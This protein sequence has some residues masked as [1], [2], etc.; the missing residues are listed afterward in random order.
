MET[1]VE[2]GVETV[3]AMAGDGDCRRDG[4]VETVVD[5]AGVETVVEMA[6]G[7]DCR[8]DGGGGDCRRDG[9]GWRLA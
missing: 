9:G 7:G 1:V 4:G 8:R 2:M 5:M 3:V 6:G